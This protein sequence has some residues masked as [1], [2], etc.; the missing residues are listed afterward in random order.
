MRK[1][2]GRETNMPRDHPEKCHIIHS[3]YYS[4]FYPGD[5]TADVF[6]F[7]EGRIY[8]IGDGKKEYDVTAF[9]VHVD[10]PWPDMEADIR[11]R[12]TAWCEIGEVIE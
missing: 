5:G 10:E 11:A 7:P 4:V 6:L 9:V 8:D 2:N 1:K 12:Y 3:D